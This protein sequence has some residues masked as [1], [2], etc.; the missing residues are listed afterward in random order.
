M[1]KAEAILA[2]QVEEEKINHEVH[3]SLQ[4]LSVSAEYK[5]KTNV[6]KIQTACN[7]VDSIFT[8]TEESVMKII[9]EMENYANNDEDLKP[10]WDQTAKHL[11]VLL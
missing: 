11:Q 1:K 10:L 8:K 7:E 4:N 6:L 5:A 2:Q 3:K 9:Q